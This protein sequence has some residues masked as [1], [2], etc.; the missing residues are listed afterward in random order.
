MPITITI[1]DYLPFDIDHPDLLYFAMVSDDKSV[2]FP[3]LEKAMA[4]F[5]GSYEYINGGWESV[6]FSTFMGTPS[7]WIFTED[8]TVDELWTKLTSEL[9][10]NSMVTTGTYVGT[11]N[12][13]D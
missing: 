12:D 13:K 6:A 4:K 3:L 5:Y 2:W 10:S 1:D 11:G 7:E 9:D 8:L